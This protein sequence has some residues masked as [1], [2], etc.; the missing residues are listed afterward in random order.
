MRSEPAREARQKDCHASER[1][2]QL[3][4][5]VEEGLVGFHEVQRLGLAAVDQLLVPSREQTEIC[6]IFRDQGDER[7]RDPDGKRRDHDAVPRGQREAC[8]GPPVLGVSGYTL[9]TVK[10]NPKELTCG[11]TA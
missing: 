7:P 9:K 1:M 2:H 10:L 4:A 5:E 3:R 11:W 8:A 6:D